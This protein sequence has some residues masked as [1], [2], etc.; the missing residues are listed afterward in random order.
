M[1][2]PGFIGAAYTLD[3]KNVDCQRCVN[4]YLEKIDSG[5]G[6]DGE[7]AF[8][9]STPGLKKLINVGTGPIRCLYTDSIGRIFSVSG[10]QLFNLTYSGGTWSSTL[11]GEDGLSGGAAK[12]FDTSSGRIKAAGMS[13]LGDGT[14]SSSLFV[15]G[16]SMQL[17]LDNGGGSSNFG[18]LV[19]FGYTSVDTATSIDWI[20]GYFLVNQAGTNVFFASDLQSFNF[21]ALEFS[22]AEGSPDRLLTVIA[23]YRNLCLFG[24]RSVE[25]FADTGNANFPFERIQGGFIEIGTIAQYSVAKADDG[26]VMW[27]G[28]SE[29]GVGIVYAANGFTPQRISTYAIERS[30]STYANPAGASAFTYQSNGHAFYVLNFDEATWVYDLMTGTW[31]ERAYTNNGTLERHRADFYTYAPVQGLHLVGDYETNAIYQFDDETYSDDGAPITRLRSSPHVTSNQA[32]V[33]CS[34]FQ[35]DIEAGVGL[36]GAGQGTDPAVMLD[37][38]NDGGH[39][40]SNETWKKIGKIGAYANRVMWMRLG[41]FRDRVFRVKITDPV[42]VTVLGANIELEVGAS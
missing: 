7:Q 21:N 25:I 38:S 4:L 20:D 32:R 41:S 24:E 39:T 42:K 18:S 2:F 15:D 19:E 31:H 40:W 37:F 34:K 29:R 10:N 27:L 30:I 35:L 9:R 16:T 23:S 26:T 28:R 1:R 13:F 17:F 14:D 5:R 36:D 3:S 11:I 22:S 12:T 8:L 6:K 33:F